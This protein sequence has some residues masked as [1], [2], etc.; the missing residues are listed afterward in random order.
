LLFQHFLLHKLLALFNHF[1]CLNLRKLK[2]H[3]QFGTILYAGRA[4]EG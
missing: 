2:L 1:I 3:I 4:T